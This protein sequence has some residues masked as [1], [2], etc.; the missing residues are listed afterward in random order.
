MLNSEPK[1]LLNEFNMY[2]WKTDV[3]TKIEWNGMNI[4]PD[5]ECIDKNKPEP[6]IFGWVEEQSNS[7]KEECCMGP[8]WW[9]PNS[10]AEWRTDCTMKQIAFWGALPFEI[11]IRMSRTREPAGGVPLPATDARCW[12][13]GEK[14][15][16]NWA[17]PV[18]GRERAKL[19]IALGEATWQAGWQRQATEESLLF[20]GLLGLPVWT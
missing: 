12:H 20:W 6:W 15:A 16:L 5:N 18:F 4:H 10:E 1:N 9:M 14:M 3:S 2:Q 17:L 13:N 8:S 11:M 7:I 19:L